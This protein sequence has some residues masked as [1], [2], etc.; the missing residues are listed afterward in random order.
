MNSRTNFLRQTIDHVRLTLADMRAEGVQDDYGLAK[1]D[2]LEESC[3]GLLQ[4][5]DDLEDG[6]W[7]DARLVKSEE[8]KILMAFGAGAAWEVARHR[9]RSNEEHAALFA[10]YDLMQRNR[11]VL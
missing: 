2:M 4:L 9:Q 10:V 8:T 11:H 7:D 3:T 1:L 5:L 6:S